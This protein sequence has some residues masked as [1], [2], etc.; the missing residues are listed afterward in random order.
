MHF[1]YRAME[2]EPVPTSLPNSLIP[3][4]KR[5][6]PAGALPGA[7]AVLPSV[8]GFMAPS[9]SFKESP[10]ST[11]PLNKAPLLSTS[12]VSLSP[13]HSFRSTSEVCYRTTSFNIF[14]SCILVVPYISV[15]KQKS[16]SPNLLNRNLYLIQNCIPFVLPLNSHWTMGV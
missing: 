5:K 12:T 3:P 7:V 13:K 9:G 1:V 14:I 2:K 8:P 6:K 4:S 11:P 10:R 15:L 16:S